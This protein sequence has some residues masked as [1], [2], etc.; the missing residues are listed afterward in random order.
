MHASLSAARRSHALLVAALA[1]LSVL[2]LAAPAR[3]ATVV[4]IADGFI[5]PLG[6]AVSSD[7]T[8]YVGEAF[9]GQ[10]TAIDRRGNRSVV[11]TNPDGGEIGGV[12]APSRGRVAYTAV[13][14]LDPEA[15]GPQNGRLVALAGQRPR[16]TADIIGFEVAENPDGDLE[17]GF[18]E[19]SDE[20]AAQLPPFLPAS[21]TGIVDSHPYA[22]ASVPGGHLVADAGGNN[23]VHV[24]ARGDVTNVAVLPP[25]PQQV[26]ADMVEQFGLP[27]CVEGLVYLGESVPTDVEV[28]P[29]GDYYVTTLPGLPEAPGAAGV[30]RIDAGTHEVEM[31][32]DGFTG[33]VD[34]AVADDGTIYVAELYVGLITALAPDGSTSI[35]AEV[36][37]PGAVEVDRRGNLYATTGVFGPSGS[38]VRIDL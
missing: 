12:D 4:P 21:Y 9:G 6:L 10:L 28:G 7:G 29:D 26:S 32:A 16:A 34:L 23:I 14:Y 35:V 36:D 31:I 22:V 20:C 15:P 2:S 17:Y 33:A 38:V 1:I 30:W 25:V 13:D 37:S 19:I 5:G 8:I 11:A 18:E 27:E 3:A 24:H